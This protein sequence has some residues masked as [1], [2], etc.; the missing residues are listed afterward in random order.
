MNNKGQITL[1]Y[2]LIFFISIIL[3]TTVVLPFLCEE[4]DTVDDIKTTMQTKAMLN[5]LSNNVNMIYSSEYGTCKNIA[6]KTPSRLN[7]SYTQNGSRNYISTYITLNNNSRR[8]VGV[9][10][11]CSISFANKPNYR[12]TVVKSNWWYYNTEV[13]WIKSD[14]GS[15]SININFK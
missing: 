1:E 10:V 4:I 12:Y 15:M 8:W 6:I 7:L 13:K 5:E 11:P 9:E 2:M 3:I 14:D